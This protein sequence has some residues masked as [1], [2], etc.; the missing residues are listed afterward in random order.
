Q[1]QKP[2]SEAT[3]EIIDVEVRRMI[4][5][6]YATTLQLLTTK[7]AEVEKVAQRL[8]EKEVLGR[9]DML[10]LLGQRPF[11]DRVQ[12]EEFVL[13]APSSSGADDKPVDSGKPTGDAKPADDTKP[14]DDA[15]KQN[16]S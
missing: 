6:A 8:L 10:N 4:N 13:D 5:D 7:R 11:K 2:Y 12:Y 14:V 15:K 1:F 3:A 9:E 16:P